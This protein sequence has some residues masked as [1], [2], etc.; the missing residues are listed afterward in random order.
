MSAAGKKMLEEIL[1]KPIEHMIL[2]RKMPPNREALK[3]YREILNIFRWFLKKLI[4]K[5]AKT[6]LLF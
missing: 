2:S 6:L 1:S 3:L 4:K 5:E